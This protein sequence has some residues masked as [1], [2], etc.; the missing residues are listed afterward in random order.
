MTKLS[1]I[2]ADA[3]ATKICNEIYEA[4]RDKNKTI[5][6]KAISDFF[7]TDVGKAVI[8]INSTFFGMKP[9]SDG[10]I[11]T[12]ALK[13]YEKV[14]HKSPSSNQIYNDINLTRL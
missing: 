11:E 12:L 14:L 3:L 4:N 7:K 10:S 1:K 2:Q 6:D 13:Y 9:L 5:K 8:K